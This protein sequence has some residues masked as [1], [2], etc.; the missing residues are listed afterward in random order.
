VKIIFWGCD[1]VLGGVPKWLAVIQGPNAVESNVSEYFR[2]LLREAQQAEEDA[3]I[4][5]LFSQR[6]GGRVTTFR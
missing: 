2:S 1:W 6:L 5:A 4:E 3:L